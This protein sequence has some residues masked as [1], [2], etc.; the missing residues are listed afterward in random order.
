MPDQLIMVLRVTDTNGT[1]LFT[2]SP[3]TINLIRMN[4]IKP[5]FDREIYFAKLREKETI[6]DP[7]LILEVNSIFDLKSIFFFETFLYI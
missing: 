3:M 4:V 7:I 5:K 6:F 1:G 2:D